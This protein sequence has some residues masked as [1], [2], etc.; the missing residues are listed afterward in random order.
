MNPPFHE[1]KATKDIIGQN[2]VTSA[3]HSL[4]KG[5]I[6]YMVSN[7]HLPYEKI[8]ESTFAKVHKICEEQGYKIF[9]AHK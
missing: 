1:G 6:L 2:F 4:K 7:L 9:E 8:M 5:G 3:H